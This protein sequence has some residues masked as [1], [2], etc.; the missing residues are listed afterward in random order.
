MSQALGLVGVFLPG[1]IWWAWQT[2]DDDDP[3][4]ALAAIF[5]V[6]MAAVALVALLFY[7]LKLP[8]GPNKQLAYWIGAPLLFVLGLVVRRK[9]LKFDWKLLVALALFGALIAL[10]LWQA[11]ELVLPNWVDSLHHSLIVRKMV[12]AGGLTASLEPYLPGNFYYHFGFHSFTALYSLFSKQ[13][14]PFAVLYLGQVISAGVSLSIYAFTKTL[15]RDWKISLLAAMLSAL[16]TKMPGYYL[17]WG[18]YTMLAGMLLMPLA[19]AYGL[20]VLRNQRG[21]GNLLALAVL[22]AG[23]LLTHYFTAFL[24]AV[25]F[26]LLGLIWLFRS[27]KARVFNWQ[28][29][30][31]LILPVL[32]GLLMVLPWYLRIFQYSGGRSDL[33]ANLVGLAADRAEQWS[34]LHYLIGNQLNL[35]LV[36]MASAGVLWSLLRNERLEF[37]LWALFMGL[38]SLPI[39][40]QLSSFR[41]DYFGLV[42]FFP[43]SV[44]AASFVVGVVQFFRERLANLPARR[45]AAVIAAVFMIFILGYGGWS[46]RDVINDIT[47]LADQDDLDALNWIDTHLPKDA[48][49]FINTA[50]W[51]FGLYRGVDGGAW[52]TPYTGRRS[53][54]PTI[55]FAFGMESNGNKLIKD[56]GEKASNITTCSGDFWDLVEEADIDYAYLSDEADV[57]HFEVMEDCVGAKLLYKADGVSIWH[58]ELIVAMGK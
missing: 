11:R 41:H 49:F 45:L 25:W 24:L 55:F 52:I 15:T 17:T 53:L 40:V 36:I 27:F 31:S 14:A 29:A 8:F 47:M 34:Y 5:G 42:L 2:R 18:R 38:M 6:S 20:K 12:E 3:G 44:M 9:R 48:R 32:V 54:V 7:L 21:V 56:W 57:L 22:T 33:S 26:V 10:R 39:G 1:L 35:I 50:P 37:A 19:M 13:F 16:V 58:L 4:E 43:I 30:F 28:T 46:N 23:T 51:G